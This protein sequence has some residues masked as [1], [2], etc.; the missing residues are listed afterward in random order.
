MDI[1]NHTLTI[2]DLQGNLKNVSADPTGT[3][4]QLK[5]KVSQ[6][7]GL[8]VKA[9]DLIFNGKAL[10]N[11]FQNLI[12]C[13]IKNNDVISLRPKIGQQAPIP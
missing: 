6:L 11:D 13:Q 5:N 1:E 7:V 8:N 2:V 3:I 12:Q 10:E 4:A 9:F